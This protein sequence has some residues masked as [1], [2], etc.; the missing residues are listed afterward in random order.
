[1]ITTDYTCQANANTLCGAPLGRYRFTHW[2]CDTIKNYMSDPLNIR[3]ERLS[4]LLFRQDGPEPDNCAASF[5]V[6]LPYSKD[7]RKACTTPA[8]LVSAGEE[9]YPVKTMLNMSPPMQLQPTVL[10]KHAVRSITGKI[11][12]LTESLDGLLLLTD[13]LEDFIVSSQLEMSS[14]GMLTQL[15]LQGSSEPQEIKAGEGANAKPLYQSVIGI[16]A[17]GGITWTSDTQGPVYRGLTGVNL[18]VQ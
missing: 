5:L 11:A 2:L 3:D 12:V 7:S 4:G 6:S 18:G 9:T 1:M 17:V 13:L 16:A 15:V 10:K 14:E 8:I